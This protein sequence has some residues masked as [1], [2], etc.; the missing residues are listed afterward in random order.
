[1][2]GVISLGLDYLLEKMYTFTL[3]AF[4]VLINVSISIY[5]KIQRYY[6]KIII[7]ISTLR[8]IC[9]PPLHTHV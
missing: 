7:L 4:I 8:S 3:H 9:T 2:N 1:M 5:P 6:Y